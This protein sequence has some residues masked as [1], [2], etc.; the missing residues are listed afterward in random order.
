MSNYCHSTVPSGCSSLESLAS[1]I[2]P[3]VILLT[4]HDGSLIL[5]IHND[6]MPKES[7][8]REDE[9]RKVDGNKISP[10]HWDGYSQC[11]G[12]ISKMANVTYVTSTMYYNTTPSTIAT[13]MPI[14]VKHY[15]K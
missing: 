9:L 15:K 10:H 7:T 2:Q 8:Q 1:T 14:W 4:Q 3:E 12:A 13:T 11:G 5:H 6:N